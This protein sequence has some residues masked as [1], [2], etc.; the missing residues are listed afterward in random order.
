MNIRILIIDDEPRWIKFAISDLGKF[1]IIVA[2]DAESALDE[3]EKD[4]FDLVIASSRHL[5]VLEVIAEKYSDKRVIVTTVRPTAQEALA[6]YRLGA[7]RYFPKSFGR[8]DLS[9][10]VEEII[11]DL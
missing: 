4:Q 7:I 1:E 2:P 10:R 8:E 5:D 3:L 11:P 6:A 9:D